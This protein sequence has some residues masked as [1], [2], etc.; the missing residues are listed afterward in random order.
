VTIN[1]D[2]TAPVV[3]SGAT[4]GGSPPPPGLTAS[5][6]NPANGATVCGTSSGVSMAVSNAQVP[7]QFVLKL[8]N[9]TTLYNQ[10]VSGMMASTTWNTTTT[11]NGPHTLNF[12]ATD[13]AGK[14]ATASVS[15]TVSNGTGTGDTTPPTVAITKPANG[16]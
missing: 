15:I 14:T 2:A 1:K 10:S 5:I 16:A 11:T 6:A 3:S 7:T 9:E 4:C 13:A 8:D 12:T